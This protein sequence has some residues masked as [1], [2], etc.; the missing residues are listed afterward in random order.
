MKFAH[1]GAL[2]ALRYEARVVPSL[3]LQRIPAFEPSR[4]NWY[5]SIHMFSTQSPAHRSIAQL[6]ITALQRLMQLRQPFLLP[7]LP[8]K[9]SSLT[10]PP[11]EVEVD[12]I[13]VVGVASLLLL[14]NAVLFGLG[15]NPQLV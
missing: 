11:F 8:V 14:V 12:D 7:M 3:S 15:M 13:D 1:E 4:Q 2:K 10:I 5:I 6:S 9:Q